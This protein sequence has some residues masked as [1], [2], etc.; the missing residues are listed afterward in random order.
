M[1]NPTCTRASLIAASACYNGTRLSA[2]DQLARRVY[3]DML[4]LQAIGGTDYRSA[5]ATLATAANTLSCGFQPDNFDAAELVIAGNNA[6]AA[7]ATLPATQ[8]AL[9]EAV[10]CL[11]NYSDFQLEQMKLLLYCQLGRG[12]AYPQ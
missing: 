12:K 5:I 6:T 8:S 3:F 4:Q 10:K 1:A 2:H 9:A 11:E 7:G